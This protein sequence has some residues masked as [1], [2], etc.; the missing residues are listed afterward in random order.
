MATIPSP[1]TSVALAAGIVVFAT[2]VYTIVYR[3]Y[4]SP[5]ARF[6]GP[7]LAAVSKAYQFYFD[8]VKA[9]KLP[10]ELVRLHERYGQTRT[11]THVYQL[12]S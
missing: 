5:L 3:I 4:L 8:V 2:V 1:A 9:G 6:P 10:F 11:H 7:K 12:T